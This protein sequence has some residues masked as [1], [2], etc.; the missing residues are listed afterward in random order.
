[1]MK[2]VL[3]FLLIFTK[4]ADCP[5]SD[6]T[7]NT[8]EMHRKVSAMQAKSFGARIKSFCGRCWGGVLVLGIG[9]LLFLTTE[10]T[11]NSQNAPPSGVPN[12]K[13]DSSLVPNPT[14]RQEWGKV[15]DSIKLLT[16]E[17][18]RSTALDASQLIG[19]SPAIT[20]NELIYKILNNYY[21]LECG[22]DS[23]K[24]NPA[25]SLASRAIEV[26]D[27]DEIRSDL[28]KQAIDKL[29]ALSHSPSHAQPQPVI[30]QPALSS[31]SIGSSAGYVTADGTPSVPGPV[32]N[33]EGKEMP[34]E[35]AANSPSE[36]GDLTNNDAYLHAMWRQRQFK[37]LYMIQKPGLKQRLNEDY[38][39]A[40]SSTWARI[41]PSWKEVV[42]SAAK[43]VIQSPLQSRWFGGNMCPAYSLAN[44]LSA[45]DQNGYNPFDAEYYASRLMDTGYTAEELD[46]DITA[47]SSLKEVSDAPWVR[48]ILET[49][50]RCIVIA[51]P[52]VKK[53]AKRDYPAAFLMGIYFGMAEI[54]RSLIRN[55]VSTSSVCTILIDLQKTLSETL[56]AEVWRKSIQAVRC[57]ELFQQMQ[58]KELL[59]NILGISPLAKDSLNIYMDVNMTEFKE[60]ADAA[61]QQLNESK[62]K[63]AEYENLFVS[64]FDQQ[65]FSE[66]LNIE[67]EDVQ[68][69]SSQNVTTDLRNGD[70][71][72][73]WLNLLKTGKGVIIG[74]DI[75][76]Y[77]MFDVDMAKS[78]GRTAPIILRDSTTPF[79]T[80]IPES[81]RPFIDCFISLYNDLHKS[82]G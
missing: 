12:D 72:M 59:D 21:E 25:C 51:R 64:V 70:P 35:M 43:P 54:N 31:S 46:V 79:A 9:V 4:I 19:L 16:Q 44:A 27:M 11:R 56:S 26:L 6:T 41:S 34:T 22:F 47:Q 3:L 28:R 30:P 55:A 20:N 73:H 49:A 29:L 37:N 62:T 5:P 7:T 45:T 23:A 38:G 15:L 48:Q 71:I 63:M 50:D 77:R 40:Q 42:N 18:P 2:R 60:K 61:K 32:S 81:W 76:H 75:S 14:T 53:Y 1:M 80:E 57:N 13:K 58:E 69:Q 65:A 52:G 36:R 10:S 82:D 39:V 74:I 66:F 8:P 67:H 78:D 68:S 33:G 17:T 24:V